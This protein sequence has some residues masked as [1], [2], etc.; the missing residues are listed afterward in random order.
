MVTVNQLLAAYARHDRV[1]A[2]TTSG[3]TV[4]PGLPDTFTSAPEA[5]W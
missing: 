5:A 4:D 2:V 1:D 3:I